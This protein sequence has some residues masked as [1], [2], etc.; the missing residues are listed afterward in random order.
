M[1]GEYKSYFD[2]NIPEHIEAMEAASKVSEKLDSAQDKVQDAYGM[3]TLIQSASHTDVG[4]I[5]LEVGLQIDKIV[6]LLKS[7]LKKLDKHSIDHLKLAFKHYLGG[8]S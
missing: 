8:A 6:P 2:S 7:A 3:L 1:S 5:S 4:I